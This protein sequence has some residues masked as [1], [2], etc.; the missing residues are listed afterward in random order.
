M[1][2]LMQEE[3]GI[4]DYEDERH[5]WTPSLAQLDFHISHFDKVLL[6]YSIDGRVIY[7]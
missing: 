7:G 6:V 4:M 5:S 1:G 3:V 2:N